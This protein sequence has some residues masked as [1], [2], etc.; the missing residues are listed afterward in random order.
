MSQISLPFLDPWFG[1]TDF[2][3]FRELLDHYSINLTHLNPKSILQVV[4]FIHLSQTFL[5]IAPHF[6]LC[7]YSY[8]LQTRHDKWTTSGG[9]G[10]QF[11]TL[12][13]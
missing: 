6:S 13:R 5:G 2:S 8:H 1:S 11:G 7:R 10:S 3:L 9:R 12:M 4:V